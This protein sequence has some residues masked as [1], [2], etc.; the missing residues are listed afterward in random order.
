M[1]RAETGGD[2]YTE[3]VQYT[4]PSSRKVRQ[5]MR[6]VDSGE[7]SGYISKRIKLN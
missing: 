6:E 7:G 1:V 5:G 4:V 2:G 3:G